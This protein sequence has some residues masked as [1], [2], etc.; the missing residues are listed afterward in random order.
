M[1]PKKKSCKICKRKIN[2]IHIELY[3]CKCSKT[4]CGDHLSDHDCKYNHLKEYRNIL[5]TRL[6]LFKDNKGFIDKI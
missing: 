2:I 3:T 6:P 1:L 5:K 4:Y